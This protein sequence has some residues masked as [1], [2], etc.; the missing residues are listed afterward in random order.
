MARSSTRPFAIRR[1]TASPLAPR[2][3]ARQARAK[4]TVEAIHEAALQ[5]L[6]EVGYD[7]LTTTR[8]AERAGVSVG[9]LY[10]YY[11][12]K[13]S[14]ARALVVEYLHAVERAMKAVLEED[15]DLPTLARHLV[16][17]FI[18]F[19]LMNGERGA[20]RRSLFILSDAQA[21][22]NGAIARVTRVLEARIAAGK[23]RWSPRRV[24]EVANMWSTFVFGATSAML[25][26][27]PEL[28]AEPWFG[29]ALEKALLALLA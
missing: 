2:K 17:R 23:P 16:Q 12:D 18:A 9:T 4:V 22:Q 24:S 13:R 6:D 25:D 11:A 8:V 5:V 10:Q 19:K 1:S 15:S 21:V 26:R 14:L 29:E 20:A 7:R 3:Q 28:V 27:A